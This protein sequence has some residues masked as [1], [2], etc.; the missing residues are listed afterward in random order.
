M[1]EPI[2]RIKKKR[3]CGKHCSSPVYALRHYHE[4]EIYDVIGVFTN[5]ALAEEE[6]EKYLVYYG[7]IDILPLNPNRTIDPCAECPVCMQEQ[8]EEWTNRSEENNK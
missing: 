5:L 1:S 8:G 6:R 2:E 4:G 7:G 3:L